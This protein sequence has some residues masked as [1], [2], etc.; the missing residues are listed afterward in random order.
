[1]GNAPIFVSIDGAQKLK[2][3]S[4]ELRGAPKEL[5]RELRRE[6]KQAGKPVVTDVRRAARAVNVTSTKGGTARPDKSTGLRDAVA[7]ATGLSI[8]SRGIRIKISSKRLAKT[9]A[10]NLAKYLDFAPFG[11]FRRWRHPV[12]GKDVWVQ[13]KGQPFFYVTIRKHTKHFRNACFRAMDRTADRL[14]K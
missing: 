7:R 14:S 8:T 10:P 1:M 12:F 13:Q 11:K 5:R 4:K 3:L 2:R 9:H 6:I